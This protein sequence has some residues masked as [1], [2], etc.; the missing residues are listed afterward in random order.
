MKHLIEPEVLNNQLD[1]PDLIIVDLCNPSLYQQQHVPGAVHLSG[2]HL[3][4]GIPPIPGACP[5]LSSL[6][7]VMAYLGI[8]DSKKVILYDDEGGGWAGRMAWSMDLLGLNNW[9]YLN[10]GAVSWLKEGFPTESTVN[11]PDSIEVDDL[12]EPCSRTRIQADEIISLL[13]NSDFAVWDARSFGEYTGDIIRSAR[14]GHIP[15]AINLEWTELM[16]RDKNLRIRNDAQ[17]ILD[18]LGLSKDKEIATHCQS[19]HRSS[20]TYMVARILGYDRIRGYDGSW[21]EWG[22]LEHM[23]V[24]IGPQK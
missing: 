14:G 12:I 24:N 15:D 21:S 16:D 22:N 7:A 23:P 11:Q 8:D 6:S 19:H 4:A 2:Q 5:T 13:D 10:G 20:F 3:I 9:Q 18:D 1:S 17:Q